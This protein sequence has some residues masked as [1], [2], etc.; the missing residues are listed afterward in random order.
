MIC[1]FKENMNY[2]LTLYVIKVSSR[3][4]SSEYKEFFPAGP[5]N[6]K[7]WGFL[8]IIAELNALV[9]LV[10]RMWGASRDRSSRSRTEKGG[11]DGLGII[12]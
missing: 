12:I 8:C 3:I 10:G 11:R 9:P 5:E 7:T 2:D 4:L 1:L 6:Q